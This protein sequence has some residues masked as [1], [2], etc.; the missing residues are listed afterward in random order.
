MPLSEGVSARI[1]Y[2][3]YAT[4]DITANELDDPATAPGTDGGQVLRRVSST[5]SLAKNTYQS[6]E[7]RNDRQ[8]VDFRHGVQRAEG[9]IA[10]EIS[11]G[12]YMDFFEA[13]HRDT[14]TAGATADQ[15]TLTSIAASHS[16]GTITFGGGDPVAAGFGVGSVIRITGSGSAID[17]TNFTILGFGGTSHR[18]VTVTPAPTADVTV[19]VTTF[20]AAAPGATTMVPSSGFIKRKFGIEVFHEDLDIARLYRECRI[21][22]YH[23]ALP[24]TGMGTVEFNVLGRA[25]FDPVSGPYFTA[26]A[27]ETNTPVLTA[28]N[29]SLYFG[30]EKVGVATSADMT[31]NLTPTPAE[32]IG[33]NF[34][35]EIFLGRANLTG[36]ITAFL[37]SQDL[38]NDFINEAEVSFLL[39]MTSSSAPDSPAMSIFMPRLKF[40]T[41]AVNLTGEGGQSVSFGFQALKYVGSAPGM[42]QTTI[43]ISDTEAA[44]GLG[45][46]SA[47]SA[48]G[49]GP[50]LDPP[51]RGAATHA[52]A[53]RLAAE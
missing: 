24:A 14:R 39:T 27:A 45:L 43:V 32:V 29:G 10:G 7:I 19:P 38:I 44:S 37:D 17:D 46:L 53:S 33:Q 21:G 26:P 50:E 22:S 5:L 6:A 51:G 42:P 30:T 4:G 2:A 36:T 41:A 13:V 34:S 40:S 1:A 12:T 49:P 11:L 48:P 28:V 35:A 25:Q 16:A 18:T 9:N 52:R 23:L 31:M 8:I 20:S 47:R 3:A 15:S